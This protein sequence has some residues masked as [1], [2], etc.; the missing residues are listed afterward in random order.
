MNNQEQKCKK[1]S[2][3]DV[4][5]RRTSEGDYIRNCDMDLEDFPTYQCNNCG[6]DSSKDDYVE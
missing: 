3:K 4:E 5:I 1:C 2:S 6:F